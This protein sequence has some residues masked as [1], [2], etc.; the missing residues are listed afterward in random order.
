MRTLI[1]FIITPLPWCIKKYI[2]KYFFHY[3]IGKSCKIGISFVCPLELEME[4]GATIGH[5]NRIYHIQLLKMGKNSIISRGNTITGHIKNDNSYRHRPNRKSILIVGK[6]SAIT[7]NHH[8]DC[9]DKIEIGDFT[10]I[11]GMNSQYMTHSIN[12]VKSYQDCYPIK[13]G[14]YCFLGS[15]VV[16][17]GNFVL[18]NYSVLAACSFS[19]QSFIDEFSLYGGI[20]AH[21]IKQLDKS[22]RYFSRENGFIR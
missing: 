8:L 18:P 9:T 6:E 11:A 7:I 22:Y 15:N 5:F 1:G 10:T 2:Y 21:K 3:K 12:L 4:D 16:V 13:I 17:L 14:N 20:P 19:K